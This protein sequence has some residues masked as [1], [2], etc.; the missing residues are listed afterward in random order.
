VAAR[1]SR[2]PFAALG[3][4]AAAAFSSWNPLSAPFALVVGL[5]SAVLAA[6]A[7]WRGGARVVAGG[8]LALSIGAVAAS[9]LVLALTAGVGRELRGE[10]IVPVP[11]RADVTR[12]LDAASERT[13]PARERARSELETLEGSGGGGAPGRTG[14]EPGGKP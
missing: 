5:A 9:A 8:A 10:A 7:L 12:D 13:R 2:L 3:F 6:R 14:R 1:R 11:G 4:A